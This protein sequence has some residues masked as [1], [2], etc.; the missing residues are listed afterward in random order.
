MSE[1]FDHDELSIS[2]LFGFLA[3]DVIVQHIMGE[4]RKYFPYLPTPDLEG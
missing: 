2:E 1:R 4:D 3:H